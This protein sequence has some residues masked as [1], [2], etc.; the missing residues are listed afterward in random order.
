MEEP[1]N[2]V[3]DVSGDPGDADSEPTVFILI[4]GVRR[5]NEAEMARFYAFLAAPD[6]DGAVRK[7]LESLAQQGFEEADLDQIGVLTGPPDEEEFHAPYAAA[8]K[9]E[10][11]LMLFDPDED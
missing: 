7:C 9:G 8:L 1:M 3:D 6:D 4:G 5:A 10:V 2:R 11:A